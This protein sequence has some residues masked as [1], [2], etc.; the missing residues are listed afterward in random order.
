MANL[1]TGT[2]RCVLF[3]SRAKLALLGAL[4]V[5][6][7]L[8]FAKLIIVH[9]GEVI[10]RS[11]N[12]AGTLSY[13][14]VPQTISKEDHKFLDDL[15]QRQKQGNQQPANSD[16]NVA[17]VESDSKP[18]PR[19]DLIVNTSQIKRARLIVNS[20]MVKRA[21]LVRPKGQ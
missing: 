5:C 3:K 2:S 11:G 13:C 19:A 16:Q 14:D 9:R 15:F 7:S 12:S 8:M 21:E 18:V 10:D 1:S 17:E 4:G 6:I 20:R